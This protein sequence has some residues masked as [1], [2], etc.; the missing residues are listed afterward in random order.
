MNVCQRAIRDS[1]VINGGRVGG[2]GKENNET[3]LLVRQFKEFNWTSGNRREEPQ[4][5]VNPSGM[6]PWAIDSSGSSG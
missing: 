3:S 6:C 1:L 4:E 5:L 2:R